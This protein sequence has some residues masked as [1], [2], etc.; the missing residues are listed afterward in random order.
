MYVLLQSQAKHIAAARKGKLSSAIVVTVHISS[1]SLAMLRLVALC[2]TSAL[3]SLLVASVLHVLAYTGGPGSG[4]LAAVFFTRRRQP[5][6]GAPPRESTPG[7]HRAVRRA[8]ATGMQFFCGRDF[9]CACTCHWV[10]WV[11]DPH[12]RARIVHNYKCTSPAARLK[13]L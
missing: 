7:S 2:H 8:A 12:T 6:P 4:V 5:D 9:A 11:S 1:Q 13:Y 10:A 3:V